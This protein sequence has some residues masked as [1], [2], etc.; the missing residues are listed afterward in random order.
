MSNSNKRNRR[1]SDTYRFDG[2][3]P[4]STVRGIFGEPTARVIT[5]VR[6]SKKQSAARVGKRK[7]AGTTDADAKCATSLVAAYGSTWR[8]KSGE[9]SVGVVAQ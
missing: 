7:A 3:R 1:L 5:L 2:F 8:S 6:R 4:L 9:F